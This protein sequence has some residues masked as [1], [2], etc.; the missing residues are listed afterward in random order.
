MT[1]LILMIMP[2][3]G[4][5]WFLSNCNFTKYKA[6]SYTG[7]RLF[8]GSAFFGIF[9]L[10]I[11]NF[12]VSAIPLL[13]SFDL[14]FARFI[15]IGFSLESTLA[16]LIG[17]VSPTIFN[18]LINKHKA[19][20]R[21]AADR[22]NFLQTRIYE[23]NFKGQLVELAMQNGE[24]YIGFIKILGGLDNEFVELIPFAS[25]YRDEETKNLVIARD[26]SEILSKMEEK[27]IFPMD[28]SI[29]LKMSE[30]VTTQLFYPEVYAEFQRLRTRPNAQS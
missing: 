27:D 23:A 28:L 11:A 8:L 4:G 20:H 17:I 6:Y 10:F 15:P 30:I 24:V 14:M 26:Y 29:T 18:P 3:V 21:S 16:M 13:N 9:F 5:Y 1:G 12:M 25:G 22:G 19:A 7:Y 2:L